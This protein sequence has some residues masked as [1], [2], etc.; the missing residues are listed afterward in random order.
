[1]TDGID[2]I[3]SSPG[4]LRIRTTLA[5]GSGNEFHLK[6]SMRPGEGLRKTT[7]RPVYL[8]LSPDDYITH[9]IM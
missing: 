9:F 3:T 5:E 7:H 1:M 8:G 2:G 6:W 4:D